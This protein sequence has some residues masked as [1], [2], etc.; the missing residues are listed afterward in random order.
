MHQ[1]HSLR[2]LKSFLVF[3]LFIISGCI[4][5]LEDDDLNLISVSKFN[6]GKSK[7]YYKGTYNGY[8]YEDSLCVEGTSFI[9]D[10]NNNH[11]TVYRVKQFDF[12]NPYNREVY[13]YWNY[14]GDL[15]TEYGACETILGST[16]DEYIYLEPTYLIDYVDMIN[17][18]LTQNSSVSVYQNGSLN[19]T[20][21]LDVVHNAVQNEI[22][23]YSNDYE[24]FYTD[25]DFGF[26]MT[27]AKSGIE[28]ITGYY[29]GDYVNL[30]LIKVK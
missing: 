21:S 30:K 23:A 10:I 20:D 28:S 27:F 9:T 19:I 13:R 17:R 2:R 25:K 14:E 24:L 8:T 5:P 11:Y 16:T 29:D 4:S 22:S 26:N 6:F 3:S 7:F 1:K 18:Y 15:L 12:M